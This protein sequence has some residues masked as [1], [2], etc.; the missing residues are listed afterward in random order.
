M[1]C[2]ATGYVHDR[3]TLDANANTQ[4]SGVSS[5]DVPC[6]G[7]AQLEQRIIT[8]PPTPAEK[9]RQNASSVTRPSV[10]TT[11]DSPPGKWRSAV[12]FEGI[13]TVGNDMGKP[14][15]DPEHNGN[16]VE[17]FP[18]LVAPTAHAYTNAKQRG[19]EAAGGQCSSVPSPLRPLVQEPP[20]K[21][22]TC[23]VTA[24]TSTQTMNGPGL[25]ATY[26]ERGAFP[27]FSAF[28]LSWSRKPLRI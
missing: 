20:L 1:H 28:K 27:T 12:A 16:S 11:V 24:P 23:R 4:G 17:A 15:E 5:H 19:E 3:I 26:P 10:K 22:G 9:P 25:P 13:S 8:V 18:S 6:F 2:E 7:V 14:Q 21:L